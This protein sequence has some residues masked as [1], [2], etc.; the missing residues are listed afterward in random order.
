MRRL[1]LDLVSIG[2][3]RS[4]G[5]TSTLKY[6]AQ[7]NF[8]RKHST[9][10]NSN[11]NNN[12]NTITTRLEAK[13]QETSSSLEVKPPGSA[14]SSAGAAIRPLTTTTAVAP[15]RSVLE[16][17]KTGPLG[18]FGSW[19]SRAQDRR[20]YVTQ[21]ASSFVI[22]LCGDLGAQLLFPSEAKPAQG[23][24]GDDDEGEEKVMAGYDPLRTMRHLAIG[25]TSS[26]PQFKW[27]MFL[28][29]NFNY[30]SKALSI[31]TKVCVQQAVFAPV[32]NSYFFS[33]QSLL[34]GDSIEETWQ[35]LKRALPS[36]LWNSIKLWPAV[37]TFSFLYVPPQF[38]SVFGGV[39]AIGWQT[40]LS[41]LN[42]RAAREV[43]AREAAAMAAGLDTAS[44]AS[45]VA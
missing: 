4:G 41:W 32:F 7:R 33:M 1:I 14:A 21:M 22:Y 9:E 3:R 11:S 28:H 45:Q 31:F 42:Q 5:N 43:A 16:L 40:Y 15:S 2:G 13:P 27:F 25:L 6:R 24:E 38:R 34:V 10:S 36:S 23:S 8:Q 17:I 30:S 35:R 18:R 12:N 26:I 39:I 19:Y 29:H 20:P 37:V 44:I